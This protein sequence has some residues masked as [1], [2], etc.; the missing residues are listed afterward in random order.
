[1][2]SRIVRSLVL[3]E[4]GKGEFAPSYTCDICSK[5]VQLFVKIKDLH[6][7]KLFVGSCGH[8]FSFL[9]EVLKVETEQE[10]VDRLQAEIQAARLQLALDMAASV[11]KDE[12]ADTAEIVEESNS[13]QIVAT[14]L[15]LFTDN[16]LG[17]FQCP[18]CEKPI[19]ITQQSCSELVKT[20]YLACGHYANI[21]FGS[22]FQPVVTPSVEKKPSTRLERAANEGN[23]LSHYIETDEKWVNF[24]PYQQVGIEFIADSGFKMLL[25]DEMGLGKTIQVIGAMRYYPEEMLPVLIV[26]PGS[27][28]IKWQREIKKWFSDKF[29]ELEYLPFIHRESIGGLIEGQK[30][31]VMSNGILAKKGMLK[32]IQGY[33]F[34]TIVIDESHQYKNPK[35][36][37]TIA[38]FELAKLVP[39]TLLLSGTSVMNRVMEYYNTLSL[40]RPRR[41]FH[42]KQLAR[43]CSLDIKGKPLALSSYYREEF[44]RETKGYILRRTKEEVL[45]DLPKK[46]VTEEWI[47]FEG[48]KTLVN[49]YNAKLDTLQDFMEKYSEGGVNA[50]TAETLFGIIAEL[51]HMVGTA[52]ALRAVEY[53]AELVSTSGEKLCIGVHHRIGIGILEESLHYKRC[54]NCKNVAFQCQDSFEETSNDLTVCPTCET[55]LSVVERRKP[56][57][58]SNETPQI[59]QAR[60][61]KFRDDPDQLVCIL[62]ILGGGIGLDIQFCP[63]VISL[64]REWNKAIEDQF[65]GRF[66]RIGMVNQVTI[67]Y[68]MA[69]GTIDEFF[70]E[71]VRL[72]QQVSDTTLNRNVEADSELMYKLAQTVVK[73][74][75]KFVGA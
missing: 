46:F 30:V 23:P 44:F 12:V 10:A 6:E 40:L 37:R 45:K 48:S 66:Q 53:A 18:I 58:I 67:C 54:P 21:S 16:E 38:L 2:T 72:K 20:Y 71:L 29:S 56:V 70:N 74:R 39:Q 41:W 62:S 28:T 51:R 15:E 14:Q 17:N 1:M 8:K 24:L 22:L 32:A 11:T 49:A 65:E 50:S 25:G 75:L 5:R 57:C 52:K 60:L 31:Y 7:E 47:S 68:L 19:A 43:M 42:P 63:N 35:S 4:V 61:D 26:C 34:K 64:E 69:Q 3:Y 36:K 9:L 73:K 13:L 55:S 33:G 27:V 59:K